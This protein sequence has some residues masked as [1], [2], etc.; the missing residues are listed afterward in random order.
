MNWEL[1]ALGIAV[2]LLLGVVVGLLLHGATRMRQDIANERS[3]RLE[4][5]RR[6]KDLERR[7]DKITPEYVHPG[8]H[9][10]GES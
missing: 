2:G 10:D 3:A 5:L 4:L 1:F 6:V 8:G 9:R 7:M